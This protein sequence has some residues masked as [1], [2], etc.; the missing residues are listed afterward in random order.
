MSK[1]T[2]RHIDKEMK[3]LNDPKMAVVETIRGDLRPV[4]LTS[5]GLALGFS[6]LGFSS[7][8]PLIHFGL[9]SSLVM[10]LAF[11]ADLLIS[12]ILLSSTKLIT[13]WDLLGMHLT[14]RVIKRSELF[15]EMTRTQIKKVVLLGQVETVAAN[16]YIVRQGERGDT[17]YLILE[18]TAKVEIETESGERML[19]G[20][21][22]EGEIFGEMALINEVERTANVIATEE[23][24]VLSIDWD[25]LRRT[26]RIFPWIS[27]QLFLNISRVLGTRLVRSNRELAEARKRV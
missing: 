9:L 8:E 24:E 22:S 21:L 7:M 10:V 3:R 25:S 11:F 2:V 17:M 13:V 14:E 6:V 16:G 12:P 18:G 1:K 5:V 27:T 20:E 19:V 15:Q 26:R 4:F 23:T